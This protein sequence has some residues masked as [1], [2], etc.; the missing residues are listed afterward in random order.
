MLG[1]EIWGKQLVGREWKV[2]F[3]EGKGSDQRLDV[4][5]SKRRDKQASKQ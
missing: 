1:V 4:T 5:T 2:Q 3:W